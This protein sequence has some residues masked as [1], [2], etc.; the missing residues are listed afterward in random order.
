[1]RQ[2]PEPPERER[3]R[4]GEKSSLPPSLP[5]LH[6]KPDSGNMS[7]GRRKTFTTQTTLNNMENFIKALCTCDVTVMSS[8]DSF[9]SCTIHL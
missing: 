7:L 8:N 9:E 4:E 1:M 5:K 3:V 2:V 6:L